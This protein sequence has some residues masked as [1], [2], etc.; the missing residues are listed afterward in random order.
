MLR[1]W[2]KVPSM[3]RVATI[4]VSRYVASVVYFCVFCPSAQSTSVAQ[5]IQP[6]FVSTVWLDYWKRI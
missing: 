3:L 4:E 2:L 5:V 6:M 1:T